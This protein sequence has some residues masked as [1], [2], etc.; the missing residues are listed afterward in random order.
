MSDIVNLDDFRSRKETYDAK[1]N[2][3]NIS[4]AKL[5]QLYEDV[6]ARSNVHDI[7]E[8]ATLDFTH[9]IVSQ[10]HE[11]DIDPQESHVAD[12]MIFIS[13]LFGSALEEF[14]TG[15]YEISD[16]KENTIYRHLIEMQKAKIL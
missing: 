8:S 9:N 2:L 4:S 13:M 11:M 5:A 15:R 1:I 14:F 16:G 3:D 6:M 7:I 10:L 12:D